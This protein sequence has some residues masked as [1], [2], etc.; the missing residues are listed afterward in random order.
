[1]DQ[2]ILLPEGN[3]APCRQAIDRVRRKGPILAPEIASST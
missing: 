1:M 2:P 3:I